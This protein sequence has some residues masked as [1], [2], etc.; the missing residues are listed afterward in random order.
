M[1]EWERKEVELVEEARRWVPARPSSSA[2]AGRCAANLHTRH[3]V[4]A[5]RSVST[6]ERDVEKCQQQA[7]K[8]KKKEVLGKACHPTPKHLFS[9]FKQTHI[10]IRAVIS[11]V[12][13]ARSKGHRRQDFQMFPIIPQHLPGH[14]TLLR[15]S[16]LR[17]KKR[18][19]HLT[20]LLVT[21]FQHVVFTGQDSPRRGSLWSDGETPRVF[22]CGQRL[23][24]L[25][26]SKGN[27]STYQVWHQWPYSGQMVYILVDHVGE[28]PVDW[29]KSTKCWLKKKKITKRHNHGNVSQQNI[30]ESSYHQK[31]HSKR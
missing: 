9:L 29:I 24:F 21:H 31:L 20:D 7:K 23:Y 25:W 26:F 19:Q 22:K 4:W 14:S 13:V 10:S 2:S 16:I 28:N 12:C 17:A 18:G 1:K 5:P 11:F 30:R 27:P 15:L 8:K 6:A 3:P